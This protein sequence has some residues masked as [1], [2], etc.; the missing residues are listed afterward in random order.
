MFFKAAIVSCLFGAFTALL[1]IAQEKPSLPNVRRIVFLGDSI[2]HDGRYIDYLDAFLATRFPDR[3]WEL[4]NL[5]LPSETVSGLS[6]DGHAGGAFPRPELRE[7]LARVLDQTKPDLLVACYGMND[8][9]YQPFDETRFAKYQQ[10]IRELRDQAATAKIPILHLTPPMFDP[11]PMRDGRARPFNY[12]DVLDRYSMWLVEQR[13]HNWDVGDLHAAI[14]DHVAKRREESP[15][16]RLADDG[17]HVN[18]TGQWLF[19]QTLLTAWNAPSQVDAAAIDWK[20]AK[21]TRGTIRDVTIADGAL[22]FSWE[23][24]VPMPMDSQWDKKSLRL[25]QAAERFNRHTLTVAGAPAAEYEIFEGATSIGTISREELADGVDLLRLRKLSTNKRAA[26]LLAVI[27]KRQRIL[28]DAW[29]SAT[30]HKRPG[31]PQGAPLEAADKQAGALDT[32]IRALAAPATLE[33][34]FMPTNQ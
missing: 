14:C 1:S 29:L 15:K 33:L 9:I 21:A 22:K 16:F 5:G 2:T 34:Q 8:G 24:R 26:E 27:S 18:A 3:R 10:G 20:S 19:A 32:Q 6:E 23:T 12:N 17:V 11:D 28:R 4:L 31:L 25:D 7:R 13:K 30:G